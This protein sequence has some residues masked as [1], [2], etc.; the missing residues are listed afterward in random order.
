MSLLLPMF[1]CCALGFGLSFLAIQ[2]VLSAWANRQDSPAARD[3]H[4]THKQPVPRLGGLGLAAGFVGVEALILFLYPSDLSSTHKPAGLIGGVLGMFLLGVWDDIRPIGARK[5][6]LGQV[7]ISVGVYLSGIGIT[8]FRIPYVGA[9]VDLGYWGCL[10]TV[11]WLV[12]MTNLVNLIDGADGLAG[13]ICLM[14]MALLTYVSHQL[15]ELSFLAAGMAG[16]LLAFL[17]FNF[18]PARIYMGDGGA[19][20]LGFLIGMMTILSSHK[21]TVAAALISPLFVLA[22]PIVDT[23]LAIIRRGMQGLPIFRPDRKH[24]HHRLMAMGVPSRK[25]V[26]GTYLFTLVFLVLGFL[27]FFSRG[28]LAPILFGVGLLVILACAGQLSFSREW[29][30]VGRVL[31]NSLEV[32]QDIQYAL[33]LAK[34]LELEAT[35]AETV[36]SLFDDFTFMLRKMGFC[37]AR[38]T[39]HGCERS[40]QA[41]D[42]PVPSRILRPEFH[43]TRVGA[44]ELGA[45]VQPDN[46]G[47]RFPVPA[48]SIP[49]LNVGSERVFE[50]LAELAAEAWFKSARK[51]EQAH[52]RPL[53]FNTQPQPASGPSVTSHSELGAEAASRKQLAT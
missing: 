48:P 40:W 9:E 35:R 15:H 4:H 3:F 33:C 41:A 39:L 11:L 42:C 43:E 32:R 23:A 30:S 2:R 38:L 49:S 53:R 12:G 50:I 36:E 47:T 26:L 1:V 44:L 16:A 34:W 45:H 14:L 19:Y 29:F 17:R 24:I 20:M 52:R 18:P 10:V 28:Q 51:W 7:L 6:L 22:L 27:A 13:G 31:G 21:G 5:K 8:H 25:V 46:P 37:Q